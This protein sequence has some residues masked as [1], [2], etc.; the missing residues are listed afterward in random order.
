M[1]ALSGRGRKGLLDHLDHVVKIRTDAQSMVDHVG[2]KSFQH[3]EKDPKKSAKS[4]PNGKPSD[5]LTFPKPKD[6]KSAVYVV[7]WRLMVRQ[8]SCMMAIL[9]ILSLAVPNSRP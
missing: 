1:R 4:E 5:L 3:T 9:V 2:V 7:S 8:E 6:M